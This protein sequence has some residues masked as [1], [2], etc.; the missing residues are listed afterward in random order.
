MANAQTSVIRIS[1]AS[2]SAAMPNNSMNSNYASFH[3]DNSANEYPT[4]VIL[5]T[6]SIVYNN[7][8]NTAT[9]ERSSIPKNGINSGSVHSWTTLLPFI[10][11]PNKNQTTTITTTAAAMKADPMHAIDD[12]GDDQIDDDVFEQPPSNDPRQSTVTFH[13]HPSNHQSQ[14][15][16]DRR[17]VSDVERMDISNM[18]V[19][20]HPS[21]SSSSSNASTANADQS[22]SDSL[23]NNGNERGN[24]QMMVGNVTLSNSAVT[25]KNPTETF[26]AAKRRT[27]SCG[28]ALQ[29]GANGK[30]PQSPA[31][32]AKGPKIRR[33]MNAFMIFSK[34]HRAMVHQ[35]HPNQDNRT[36]S[37]ILGEWWYALKPEEKN[38]YHELASEVKEAHFRTYPEWKWCSKDR[39]KSSSSKDGRA[40]TDSFD[41]I[42]QISPTTPSEH[43]PAG[44]AI[45][46][47]ETAP[48]S[49]GTPMETDNA[50]H[51]FGKCG[52][53]STIQA[54]QS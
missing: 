27:Q 37:K 6:N 29:L 5:T 4:Q 34:R 38:Q 3:G 40:R 53:W 9:T 20:S 26:A 7:G 28:A 11:A 8:I 50:S 54:I 19:H 12:D 15:V 22:A 17:T 10:E 41:G 47:E 23:P 1:P 42:E 30:E 45:I 2:S 21:A 52:D 49:P 16:I 51:I 14:Q 44:T 33:P 31:V 24:G 46:P 43:Y 35:K 25:S 18:T 39:R 13:T 32:K 36:V 48:K